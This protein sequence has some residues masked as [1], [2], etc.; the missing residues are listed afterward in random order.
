MPQFTYGED[1]GIRF[2]ELLRIKSVDAKYLESRLAL[3]FYI[4]RQNIRKAENQSNK[5]MF[6]A[7]LNFLACS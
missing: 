3:M 6:L 7:P 4:S 5:Y 1:N 2:R